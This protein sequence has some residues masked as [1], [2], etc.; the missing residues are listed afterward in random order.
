MGPSSRPVPRCPWD[1]TDLPD[2]S[3]CERRP[4]VQAQIGTALWAATRLCPKA[5]TSRCPQAAACSLD[6]HSP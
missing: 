5:V 2:P 4:L 6:D 3:T 1:V